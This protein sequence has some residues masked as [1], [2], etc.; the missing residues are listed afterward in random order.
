MKHIAITQRV[1]IIEN[2]NE[3]RDALSQEWGE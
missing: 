3:R 1:E 2:I